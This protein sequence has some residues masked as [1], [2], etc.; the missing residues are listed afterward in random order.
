M[1]LHRAQMRAYA[2]AQCDAAQLVL[3]THVA[4]GAGCC[5]AC[6]RPTPCPTRGEAAQLYA[7]YAVWL[8]SPTA[9]VNEHPYRQLVRPHTGNSGRP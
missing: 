2:L 6:G 5:A 3:T 1:R 8:A 7:R 4:D 9:P